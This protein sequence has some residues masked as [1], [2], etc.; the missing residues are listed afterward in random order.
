MRCRIKININ[1][2]FQ[3]PMRFWWWVLPNAS[4]RKILSLEDKVILIPY[5][6]SFKFSRSWKNWS[7]IWRGLLFLNNFKN[8]IHS[9]IATK[10]ELAKQLRVLFLLYVNNLVWLMLKDR[11]SKMSFSVHFQNKCLEISKCLSVASMT[12]A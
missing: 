4:I 1:I 8:K 2:E 10:L 11:S 7:I 12:V 5:L 9:S 3:M 6:S